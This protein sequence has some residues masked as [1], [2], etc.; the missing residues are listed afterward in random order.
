MPDRRHALS[1]TFGFE[2]YRLHKDGVWQLGSVCFLLYQGGIHME[3]SQ[4]TVMMLGGALALVEGKRARLYAKNPNAEDLTALTR[5]TET[6]RES[7]VLWD[8][9]M[10]R[11]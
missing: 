8:G 7:L 2:G 6:L 3:V 11:Y 4:F 1:L 5:L 10:R 9:C